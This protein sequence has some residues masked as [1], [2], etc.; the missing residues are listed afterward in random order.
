MPYLAA[1]I[2]ETLRLYPASFA[3]MRQAVEDDEVNGFYIPK[4]SGI[5]ISVSHIHRHP[6]FWRNPEGF[7][8]VRFIDNPLGQADRYAY[9]PFGAGERNCIGS[10]FSTMEVTLI[11]AMIL[12]RFHIYLPP[13]SK[14][15]PFITSLIAMRPNINNMHIA[16]LG[17]NA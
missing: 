5:V 6:D 3:I 7:D 8:P 13:N 11:I 12:Q 2:K 1:V 14:I 10:F 15:E 16:R 9:I 4:K 17:I